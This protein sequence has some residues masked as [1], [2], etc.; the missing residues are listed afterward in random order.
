M[1]CPASGMR[2]SDVKQDTSRTP[3]MLFTDFLFIGWLIVPAAIAYAI[4]LL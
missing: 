1:I 3:G 4:P 2:V